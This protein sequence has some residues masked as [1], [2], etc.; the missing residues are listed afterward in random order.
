M[1][2][3]TRVKPSLYLF[4]LKFTGWYALAF[5]PV[6]VFAGVSGLH[7]DAMPLGVAGLGCVPG[8]LLALM[9]T[10]DSGR[11]RYLLRPSSFVAGFLGYWFIGLISVPIMGVVVVTMALFDLRLFLGQLGLGAVLEMPDGKFAFVAVVLALL[12]VL[13][14][15]SLAAIS[16]LLVRFDPV[17]APVQMRG[18]GLHARVHS[19]AEHD[20]ALQAMR[21][22]LA[23]RQHLNRNTG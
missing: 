1:S 18:T 6:L 22:R 8:A 13:V 15:S 14:T 10:A 19:R 2:R 3:H 7:R 12:P 5:L 17:R 23:Q 20:A 4:C 9:L 21:L 11:P 16:A